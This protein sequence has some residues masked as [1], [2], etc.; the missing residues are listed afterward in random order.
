MTFF[1]SLL[2]QHRWTFS[3]WQLSLLFASI[4]WNIAGNCERLKV[5]RTFSAQDAPCPIL[6]DTCFTDTQPNFVER[7]LTVLL[8]T[9]QRSVSI[10]SAGEEKLP[11]SPMRV[12][13]S[14]GYFNSYKN[15]WPLT[16]IS[17]WTWHDRIVSCK[18]TAA[19][20]MLGNKPWPRDLFVV[21]TKVHRGCD[22][23]ENQRAS[24]K[25]WRIKRLSCSTK[26]AQKCSPTPGHWTISNCIL[27]E[28]HLQRCKDFSGGLF[29]VNDQNCFFVLHL[30]ACAIFQLLPTV[31]THVQWPNWRLSDVNVLNP[32]TLKNK[33][34]Q[35]QFLPV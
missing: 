9:V 5:Q 17:N 3:G 6:P 29:L 18:D 4:T 27:F 16:Y 21:M 23:L 11:R 32:L 33:G 13:N 19:K 12:W 31:P 14:S 22:K 1:Y 7:K 28:S 30:P 8:Y 35:I 20:Q 24:V 10:Q 25:G 26:L 2:H 15:L 34:W